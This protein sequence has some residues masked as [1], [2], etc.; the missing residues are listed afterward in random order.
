MRPLN[1]NIL[2][3]VSFPAEQ[4]GGLLYRDIGQE[5][6]NDN[7]GFDQF[8]GDELFAMFSLGGCL[9][10]MHRHCEACRWPRRAYQ[11]SPGL[12]WGETPYGD[13]GE[14]RRSIVRQNYDSPITT[15][16][17]KILVEHRAALVAAGR[18]TFDGL[19]WQEIVGRTVDN[20]E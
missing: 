2:N 1:R 13:K 4:R 7:D 14:R 12:S 9:P 15:E 8:S 6:P 5:T 17:R 20:A 19:T 10:D 18:D 16:E 11:G 3:Y